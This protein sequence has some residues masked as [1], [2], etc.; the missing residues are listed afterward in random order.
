MLIVKLNT[1]K[2]HLCRVLP[3]LL[4]VL[5]MAGNKEEPV[6]PYCNIRLLSGNIFEGPGRFKDA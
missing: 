2:Y 1:S 4:I 6:T 3:S 5:M